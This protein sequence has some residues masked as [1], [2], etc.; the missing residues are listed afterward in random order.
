MNIT[1]VRVFLTS[2]GGATKAFASVTFDDC[3]VVKDLRIVDGKNGL[4]V[5]MPS[6]RDQSG[7]FRD[8]CHPINTETR[9]CIQ[10]AVLDKYN[11]EIA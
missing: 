8:I 2:R 6:R 5:A 4:F 9:N 3:F 10:D 11:Q 1:D 7:E